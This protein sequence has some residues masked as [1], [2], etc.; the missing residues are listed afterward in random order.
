MGCSPP[1]SCPWDLLGKN[2]WVGCHFLLQRIFLTQGLKACLLPCRWILYHWTTGEAQVFCDFPLSF[3]ILLWASLST[4][5][6][7][8]FFLLYRHYENISIHS[9]FIGLFRSCPSCS[10]TIS[11]ATNTWARDPLCTRT[12]NFFWLNE[13]TEKWTAPLLD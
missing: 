3:R 13:Y 8:S 1:G 11:A 5:C 4:C 6:S 10:N 12:R 7:S 2:T 9:V